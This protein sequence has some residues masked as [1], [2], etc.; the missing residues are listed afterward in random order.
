[1]QSVKAMASVNPIIYSEPMGRDWETVVPGVQGV[2]TAESSVATK[3]KYRHYQIS[4]E[5]SLNIQQKQTL[6]MRKS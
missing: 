1:M 4:S 3:N 5:T 2:S 6:G